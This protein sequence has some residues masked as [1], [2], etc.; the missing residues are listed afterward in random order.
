MAGDDWQ[1]EANALDMYFATVF[2]LGVSANDFY[3]SFAGPR[4]PRPAAGKLLDKIG[5]EWTHTLVMNPH[6]AKQLSQLLARNV[7]L[8]EAEFGELKTVSLPEPKK[9]KPKPKPRSK[10]KK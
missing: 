7:E 8:Y 5:L 1:R 10:R 9:P 4:I 3:L 2:N 6:A